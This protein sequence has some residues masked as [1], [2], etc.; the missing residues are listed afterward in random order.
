M[1]DSLTTALEART[2]DVPQ[3]TITDLLA[4]M[5]PEIEKALP[6]HLTGERFGRIVLT[7]LRRTPKLY[8]CSPE[9]LLGAVM[10]SAQ[11]GLEPGPLGH[12]YLIPFKRTVQ[13][14]IG[15]RGYIDLA[16]R[17]G[18]LRSMQ[19]VT[20]REGDDFAYRNGT[21]S[22]LDHTPAGAPG[23]RAPVAWYAVATLKTGGAPFSVI[24]PEDVV[25]ARGMSAAGNAPDGPWALHY[26]AMARK[27]AV[28][29]LAPMLPMTPAFAWALEADQTTPVL[30]ENGATITQ[31]DTT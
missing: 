27:T 1:T 4:R 18:V 5:A 24:Y 10:V 7:E 26:D 31:G 11:L 29:R 16:Y 12:V 19:A 3:R 13:L 15:Y 20:V 25:K 23:E 17:S 8:D 28:R 9:S 21:R 22:F 30:D 14:V 6:A 2:Q